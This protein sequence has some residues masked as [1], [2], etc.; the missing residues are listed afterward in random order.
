[1]AAPTTTTTASETITVTQKPTITR[2]EIPASDGYASDSSLS[3][4]DDIAHITEPELLQRMGLSRD[5]S[6][7]PTATASPEAEGSDDDDEEETDSDDE[8]WDNEEF[9][10]DV[11]EG[12]METPQAEEGGE[13]Q[14]EE[15]EDVI[16]E[17]AAAEEL[18][19]KLKHLAE[20]DFVHEVIFEGG[21]SIRR[22]LAAFGV[23]PPRELPDKVVYRILLM[24]LAREMTRRRRLEEWDTVE[25]VVELLKTRKR[26][27]VLTGAGISTSLGIPDFRSKGSGL[28][29]RLE[30][31]G[32][33]DPQE[34]F[35][36]QVFNDD[37][38]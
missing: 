5:G 12:M 26:I 37:P 38:T 18:R 16:W 19:L 9:L 8:L 27:V 31:L 22:C 32:L 34:V 14:E 33:S 13:D 6:A 10:E 15:D 30:G 17:P 20:M 35:D 7:L 24:V 3:D 21:M 23:R 29:A 1:M 25:D 2:T 36:I 4:C 28:Y 11:V